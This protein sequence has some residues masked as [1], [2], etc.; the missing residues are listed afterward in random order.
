MKNS[1]ISGL[2]LRTALAGGLVLLAACDVQQ[3]NEQ[4]STG[5]TV[6]EANAK[7]SSGLYEAPA[8]MGAPMETRERKTQIILPGLEDRENYADLDE[9]PVHLVSQAPVST[10]SVDVDTGSYTN[11][12]RYLNEGQLPPKEAVRIEE[13]VNYFDY[14]YPIPSDQDAPFTVTTEVAPTPWNGNTKLLHIGIK[15]YDEPHAERPPANLVFLVDVSGSMQARDKLP[16]LQS[17]LKLLVNRMREQDRIALVTY[18]GNTQLVLEPTAGDEKAKIIRAI[19]NLTAG[20]STNGEAGI[21]LAYDQAEE[22][23]I[24]DGINRV[25]LATDGDLNVGLSN[26][27]KLRDLIKEKRKSGVSLSVL[28][29]GTGNLNDHLL[30]QVADFGNGNYAYIDTLSEAR[31]VLV[32]EISSTLMTVAKDV[33]LQVEFNPGI[34]AEYRLIGYE[35][36]ALKRED[37]NNDKV[38]AGEIGAGHTVT[39]LYEVALVGSNGT[40]VDPLRYSDPAVL[41]ASQNELAFIKVRYKEPEGKKSKLLE[42]PVM[43]ADMHDDLRETGNRFRFSAAVAAFGHYLRDSDYLGEMSLL[44]IQ[45]LAESS[46]GEDIQGYRREFVT[47]LEL[48][49]G[50]NLASR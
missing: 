19:D 34:V 50:L 3:Q 7:A 16:L 22:T 38:D 44:D 18:A 11:M 2:L 1:V 37:F 15:A 9:S 25:I 13:F 28:G 8:S 35:N 12:R 46:L 27:D 24:E 10:F 31:K 6:S 48:A 40:K 26:V 32:E 45:E 36:R 29:F 20:G 21:N 43:V 42:Y 39:A 41:T 4:R 33:K 23:M 14:D 47:L 49:D 30:E 5:A 17:S